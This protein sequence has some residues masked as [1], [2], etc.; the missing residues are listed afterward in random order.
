MQREE[1]ELHPNTQEL[2][3]GY[4]S[5]LCLLN[6]VALSS[7]SPGHA[8]STRRRLGAG[9]AGV[10]VQAAE[11][12]SSAVSDGCACV[13]QGASGVPGA[14]QEE[15]QSKRQSRSTSS[16][17]EG[18]ERKG[19]GSAPRVR[20]ARPFLAPDALLPPIVDASITLTYPID[21]ARLA[22]ERDRGGQPARGARGWRRS[23]PPAPAHGAHRH[24]GVQ[25]AGA[26]KDGPQQ[27]VRERVEAGGRRHACVCPRGRRPI[28]GARRRGGAC[29]QTRRR[30]RGRHA[31]R[32]AVDEG[33][34]GAAPL[35]SRR[36]RAPRAREPQPLWRTSRPTCRPPPPVWRPRWT[37]WRRSSRRRRAGRPRRPSCGPP[38]SAY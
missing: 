3:E 10:G 2:L 4:Q 22:G 26:L 33:H 37:R 32:G 23:R 13:Q 28:R 8:C 12:R 19:G 17:G 14:G 16:C 24:R 31:V 20:A 5:P 7:T 35:Q 18:G 9:C 27:V 6:P 38:R 1:Q 15:S 25:Q 30:C 11:D 36:A 29:R 21:E 34:G